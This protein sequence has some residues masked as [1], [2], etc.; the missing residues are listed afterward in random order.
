MA[1]GICTITAA[2]LTLI[3]ALF[4]WPFDWLFGFL[5][6]D[7]SACI[8]LGIIFPVVAI[9][10]G[11]AAVM[12]RFLPLA[13]IGAVFGMMTFAFFGLAFVL[14]LVGLILIAVG[15]SAFLPMNMSRGPY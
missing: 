13:I 11:L 14:G 1:G 8:A 7:N 9:I 10:G 3:N 12:K 5:F 2:A 6:W 4:I 15:H